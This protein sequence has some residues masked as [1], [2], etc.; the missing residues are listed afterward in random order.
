MREEA[1]QTRTKG[2]QAILTDTFDELGAAGDVSIDEYW[3]NVSAQGI[4][5]KKFDAWLEKMLETGV[6]YSP[7]H[8][9]LR[10]G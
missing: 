10:K 7:R 8:G 2:Q 1:K 9:Y 5:R 4:A 6:A 3:K